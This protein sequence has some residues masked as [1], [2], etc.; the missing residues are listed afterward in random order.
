[1]TASAVANLADASAKPLLTDLAAGATAVVVLP[2]YRDV[3]AV[4]E[5]SSWQMGSSL[6]GTTDQLPPCEPSRGSLCVRTPACGP[7]PAGCRMGK[8]DFTHGGTSQLQPRLAPFVHAIQIWPSITAAPDE[9]ATACRAVSAGIATDA[10]ECRN[11]FGHFTRQTYRR[12]SSISRPSLP[13]R[14]AAPVVAT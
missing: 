2:E 6:P 5:G 3:Q 7:P 12:S 8:A 11:V 10:G 1:V 4:A 9:V 14:R 13:K